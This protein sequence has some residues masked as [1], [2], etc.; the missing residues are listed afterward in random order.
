MHVKW[1]TLKNLFF[2]LLVMA[3]IGGFGTPAGAVD[4]SIDAA[5]PTA[6]PPP[7]GGDILFPGPGIGI[8]FAL[9]GLVPEDEVDALSYEP[10]SLSPIGLFFSVDGSA[11]GAPGTDVAIE[12]AFFEA[13]GDVFAADP[14]DPIP[15]NFLVFDQFDLG[16]LAPVPGPLDNLD[17]LEMDFYEGGPGPVYFSLAPGSPTLVGMGAGP[18]DILSVFPG[19]GPPVVALSA[20]DLGLGPGDNLDA[21]TFMPPIEVEG[22]PLVSPFIFSIDAASPSP[23]APGDVLGV[24]AGPTP[25]VLL[26]AAELGLLPSDELDALD[27]ELDDIEPPGGFGGNQTY[28]NPDWEITLTDFGYSDLLFY[29]S[30]PFPT[31][32]THEMISGEWAAAIGYDDIQSKQLIGDESMWLQPEFIYPDW[33]SNSLF[34][35]VSPITPPWGPGSIPNPDLSDTD[36]LPYGESTISND[37]VEIHI[38]YD[39]DDTDTGTP[40]GLDPTGASLASVMSNRY[41]L[42][43][44]YEVTNVSGGD[45]DNVRFYQFIHGH[46]ANAETPTVNEVYDPSLYAGP[47]STFQHDITQFATNSGGGG[48]HPTGLTFEDHIGFSSEVLP[49]DWGLGPYR[50]HGFGKPV[51]GPHLDVEGDVLGNQTAFGPDEVAGAERWTLAGSLAPGATTSHEVLLTVRST[52]GQG[53]TPGN[54][55]MPTFTLPTDPFGFLPTLGFGFDGIYLPPSWDDFL[56]Y[57]PPPSIGYDYEQLNPSGPDFK[58]VLLPSFGDN[59]YDL[60][61]FSGGVPYNT[62]V[63]LTGGVEY[64]FADDGFTGVDRFRILGIES[65]VDSQ[66]PLGFPTGIKYT[67]SGDVDYFQTPLTAPVPEP[68]SLALLGTGILG[69]IGY[70]WRRRKR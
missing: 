61:L 64:T 52:L 51:P 56:F 30:G 67:G 41:V 10:H 33:T 36:G 14:D 5:S 38:T 2:G 11:I 26:T 42:R 47:L 9:L 35:V 6:V 34:Y 18:G 46:P 60:W 43:Q 62:G 59:L 8:P 37:D 15:D 19:G 23:F 13:A 16:L 31:E 48:G 63:V 29:N 66:D 7:T 57:D 1:C 45:L 12:A 4:F 54:P 68:G 55:S 3:L 22:P 50:G 53:S 39:M 25:T 32:F 69:L 17:A 40:M 70:G 65:G 58:S 20:G 27:I 21:L 49:D 28:V 44:E 24:T